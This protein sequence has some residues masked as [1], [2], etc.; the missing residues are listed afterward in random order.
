MDDEIH[1]IEKNDTW[2]LTNLLPNKRP[3]EVGV[4]D[5]VQSQSRN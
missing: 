3:S 1:G 4:Q 2:E 5:K